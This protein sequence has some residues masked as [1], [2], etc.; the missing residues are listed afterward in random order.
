M[1]KTAFVLAL[2]LILSV[3]TTAYAAVPEEI[4]PFVLSVYP[5]IT[6]DGETA[7]C[8]VTVIGDN[9]ND[10]ISITMRLWS[11]NVCCATWTA[12]GSGYLQVNRTKTVTAG[13]EYRLTVDVTIN[14]ITKPTASV[15][16]TC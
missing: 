9:M 13:L 4:T 1:K 6:F 12:A 10:S 2:A 5:Q 11:G 7:N 15:S 8:T 14:G 3:T 16:G